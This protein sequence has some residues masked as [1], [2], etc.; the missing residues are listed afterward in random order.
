ME[1]IKCYGNQ[2]EKTVSNSNQDY[3]T[4]GTLIYKQKNINEQFKVLVIT[5]LIEP[6]YNECKEKL[7]GEV[8]INNFMDIIT[9][10]VFLENAKTPIVERL[11]FSDFEKLMLILSKTNW[12]L[13]ND[14]FVKL[15]N[16]K[17]Y[18]F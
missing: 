13:C 8:E 7:N 12:S 16:N 3:F 5:S 14:I 18:N 2:V 15:K 11:Y 4:E 1:L 10:S 17:S 9:L 6:L